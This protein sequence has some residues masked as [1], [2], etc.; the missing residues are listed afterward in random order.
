MWS[1]I[2]DSADQ[3]EM[4]MNG[5]MATGGISEKNFSFYLTGV[6]G[7]SYI[8]FEAPNELVMD[9]DI[10]WININ[11]NSDWWTSDVTSFRF[12]STHHT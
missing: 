9:G 5:L 8:D 6:D 12:D 4:F 7:E 1:E 3:T 11:E 2:I 10:I